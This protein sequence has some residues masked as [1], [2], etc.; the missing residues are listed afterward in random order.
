MAKRLTLAKHMLEL[1]KALIRVVMCFL[2]A[3]ACGY[4]YAEELYGLLLK[5][6][7]LATSATSERLLIYTSLTEA[8]MSYI[9]LAFATAILITLPVLC[10]QILWFVD[11]G[12][13][14]SEKS[15]ARILLLA[16]PVLFTVGLYVAYR[17]V[18]PTAWRFFL[19]FENADFAGLGIPLKAHL[20]LGEYLS[21]CVQIMLAFGLAFQ[22][23]VACVFLNRI[24]VLPVSTLKSHRKI[25]I[26]V[27]FTI[28]AIITPPDALSQIMLACAMI[29]LY[30]L[31]IMLCQCLSELNTKTHRHYR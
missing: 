4:Y 14:K 18:L 23:P 13:A 28:A 20:K 24:G 17:Y 22:L 30:E 3:F 15:L 5:P 8:F 16:M 2:A 27:I 31:A 10:V 9:E 6:Y 25:V 7:I 12:L 19:S 29:L 21:L 11:P 26:V 1:R